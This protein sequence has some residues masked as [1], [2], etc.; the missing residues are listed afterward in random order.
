MRTEILCLLIVLAVL[1][2][3]DVDGQEVDVPT[4]RARAAAN[5]VRQ[6]RAVRVSTARARRLG[7]LDA[8]VVE[9]EGR[10]DA[11]CHGTE[12][13]LESEHSATA[14]VSAPACEIA[15]QSFVTQRLVCHDEHEGGAHPHGYRLRIDPT[16]R[17]ITTRN[18][19][20]AS[21]SEIGTFPIRGAT[22]AKGAVVPREWIDY[23]LRAV[24]L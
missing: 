18:H 22:T 21:D 3:A 1:G 12:A 23:P 8:L 17:V 2:A 20:Y 10:G 7:A 6:L 9:V 19:R 24:M 15:V 13:A 4:L 16:G 14:I 11:N 5:P